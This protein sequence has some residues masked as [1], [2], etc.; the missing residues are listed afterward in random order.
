MVTADGTP[1]TQPPPHSVSTDA[2]STV[3]LAACKR[4][5]LICQ[6][7]GPHLPLLHPPYHDGVGILV[8]SITATTAKVRANSF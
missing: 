1:T 4:V 5:K 2:A 3:A 7:V 8:R 6:K